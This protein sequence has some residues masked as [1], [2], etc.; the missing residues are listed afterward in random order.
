M[1]LTL[2]LLVQRSFVA[3]FWYLEAVPLGI[4]PPHLLSATVRLPGT[5]ADP[6]PAVGFLAEL[7]A[8]VERLPGV[9]AAG[10]INAAPLTVQGQWHGVFRIKVHR[11]ATV[12]SAVLLSARSSK[13][14]YQTCLLK[15]TFS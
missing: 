8:R 12:L 9:T 3:K 2:V 7:L 4:A 15:R 14:N 13:F 1:G 11:P 6:T 5:A 10:A